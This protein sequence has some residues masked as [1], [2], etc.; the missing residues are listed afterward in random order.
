MMDAARTSETLVNFY[1]T[2]RRYYPEDSHLRT[3]SRENLKSY[4]EDVVLRKFMIMKQKILSAFNKS[5]NKETD[6]NYL[7]G[8]KNVRPTQRKRKNLV[9]EHPVSKHFSTRYMLMLLLLLL[10][11]LLY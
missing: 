8:L 11:L 5:A 10:L 1:Q 4:V 9:W 3:H 7:S 2:A 6:D